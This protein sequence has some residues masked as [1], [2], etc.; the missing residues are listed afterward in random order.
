MQLQQEYPLV[1]ENLSDVTLCAQ[2]QPLNDT[3]CSR[4]PDAGPKPDE[5][6]Y[7]E[8]RLLHQR[9][10]G[11][12]RPGSE[13][14]L[15]ARIEY[16]G[17]WI[18]FPLESHLPEKAAARACEIYR[19]LVNEG[20]QVV[21]R[22][23][24][25]QLVWAIYWF[26]EP[27]ACTY[28][29]LFTILDGKPVTAKAPPGVLPIPVALV[30]ADPAVSRGLEKCLNSM[31]GYEC[32]QTASRAKELLQRSVPPG[33][34]P[35]LV[36]FNQQSLDLPAAAFQRQLQTRWPGAIAIP[37]DIFGHSD[38][39]FVSVAGLDR[40]YFLRRRPPAQILEP[41]A[42]LWQS[43]LTTPA[44]PRPHFE[45]YFQK[46]IVADTWDGGAAPSYALTQRET[47]ILSCLGV[48]HTDKT[49][50]SLL[51][52]SVWTVHAHVKSIF[53]KL[54]VHTRAEAVMRHQKAPSAPKLAMTDARQVA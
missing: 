35:R 36:L 2:T 38:P 32:V 37:F 14:E 51:G 1:S 31:P 23:Y 15:F 17:Q 11:P 49:M 28:A 19:A 54:G 18:Y 42:N 45:S 6:A 50:S 21:R 30:E 47:Q 53:E 25:R 34:R 24:V 26:T 39:L 52:I 41:M 33:N 43:T 44:N 22:R 40:G 4:L 48:G 3:E 29:T 16:N 7:W 10:T 9:H 27:L 13:S 12:A 5:A 20:W 46:L 8:P